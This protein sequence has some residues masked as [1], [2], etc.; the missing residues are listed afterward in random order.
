MTQQFTGVQIL[1]FIAAMLVVVMHITQAISIHITGQGPSHHWSGGSAGVDIFFV[2]SG[3]VMA[4][5]TR[6][7]P[8]SSAA[9]VA[10]AWIFMKRRLLRIAPLYWF[11]T[12]LKAALLLALP[13]LASRSSVESGHLAASLL[14]I[15]ATSPWGFI[16]PT[17]PV[18]WTLNFEMLFY[19]VFALALAL[20]APRIRFCLL[21]FLAIF[22][23]GSYIPGSVALAFYANSIVF[24]FIL[25]VCIAQ[26]LLLGPT[27]APAMGPFAMIAGAALM[28]AV[29]GDAPVDRLFTWGLGAALVVLGAVWLEPWT[30]RSRMASPL[31]FLGDASYS[32]YL[33]HT[34]VVPAGVLALKWLGVESGL[35]IVLA[36]GL[37]VIVTG[38]FSYLW[39]ERPMT[40]FLKRALFSPS[41]LSYQHPGK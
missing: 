12:L 3:F 14:F 28:F 18:G 19:A 1:R 4:M 9:R 35:V 15:P 7:P 16:Q 20:G 34:F 8:S 21:V 31:S 24:E 11:Y 2:I 22:L 10:A 26:V 27:V 17:L 38:C 30:A 32:I 29:G 36:V 5:S 37:L 25:G 40:S 33:S 6:T 13:T 23:A 41:R 39:L